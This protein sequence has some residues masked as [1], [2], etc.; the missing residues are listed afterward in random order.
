[1]TMQPNPVPNP[2]LVRNRGGTTAPFSV[3]ILA[4]SLLVA[5]LDALAAYA[6]AA[7]LRDVLQR[8]DEPEIDSSALSERAAELIA[9]R[10]QV[11]AAERYRA[12]RRFR[13]S[14][15]PLV[16]CLLGAPGVGKATVA[17]HLSLRLGIH[18]VVPTDAIREVLRTVIPESALPE[19][20]A[21]A[22]S[23][24]SDK[25]D[26]LGNGFRRQ[27]RA[28]SA[29]AAA[30]ADRAVREGRDIMLFGSHLLP[31]Q[32][33]ASLRDRG[34]NAFVLEL[35][36]TLHDERLHRA[37][38]LRRIR[39]EASMP[40]VRHVRNFAAVRKLQQQLSGLA[41]QGNVVSHDEAGAAGLTEWIVD[42]VVA[43]H[44][45]AVNSAPR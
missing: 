20:H 14:G 36:L 41:K 26:Q 33:R 35:F 25:A 23:A 44:E 45:V 39:S 3:E 34:C 29:A 1:M 40:G 27:A 7:E 37:R 8:D 19:L 10:C 22:Y 42:H 21:S 43:A 17:T 15:R 2:F 5:G 24:D 28:V 16:L 11:A 32:M 31:G 30:V 38:M 6:I 18:R 13:H 4:N 9:Q 12:W